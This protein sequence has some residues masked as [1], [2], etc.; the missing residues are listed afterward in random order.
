MDSMAS[1]L[2][3]FGLAAKWLLLPAA[4]SVIGF[5]VI[6]PRMDG[7]DRSKM[8]APLQALAADATVAEA[9]DQT[10]VQPA[11]DG[12]GPSVDVDVVRY[13]MLMLESEQPRRPARRR[14][15]P[16]PAP[17]QQPLEDPVIQPDPVVEPPPS[18][19]VGS[20]DDGGA[21][22]GIDS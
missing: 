16:A 1:R 9:P 18:T 4:L 19:S 8:P 22:E 21:V 15:D 14:A 5:F 10:T 3:P 12:E 20:G 6:G 2:T 7:V 17:R 11:Y 13:R